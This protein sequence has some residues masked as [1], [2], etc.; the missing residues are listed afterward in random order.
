M[1]AKLC[2]GI[3]DSSQG[4]SR[5]DPRPRWDSR[6]PYSELQNGQIRLLEISKDPDGA[7]GLL[8]CV[9]TVHELEAA[10]P[11]TALSYTWGTPH[12]DIDTLRTEHASTTLRINCNGNTAQ[13]GEN[14]YDFLAHCAS[15]PSPYS[16]GYL[17]IDALAINQGDP[18]E[19]CEQVKLMKKIYQR[20]IRVVAWLGPADCYT[21]KAVALMKALYKLDIPDRYCLHPHNVSTDHQNDLLISGNWDAVAQFFRR[22]WFNRTWM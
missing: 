6:T 18:E 10:P 14:L 9:L 8:S 16:E 13:V 5:P 2:E 20:A 15:H 22:E 3:R 7:S 4:S 17:W 19:R 21:E 1:D 11:F 12:E